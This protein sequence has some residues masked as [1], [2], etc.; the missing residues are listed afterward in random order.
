MGVVHHAAH[1]VWLEE[2]RSQ[3][4][5]AYGSSFTEFEKEGLTLPVSELHV[6]Y[7]QPATYDQLV[8]IRCWIE[9]VKSRKVTFA[10]EVVDTDSKAILVT[11]Y[12]KHIC[13]DRQGNV[14]KI[15]DGWRQFLS[16]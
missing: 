15:P 4:L 16:Q 14:V 9:E 10:Y 11:G 13:V 3:W 8:T 7:S 5:R 2:G 6:R 1:V 12:T